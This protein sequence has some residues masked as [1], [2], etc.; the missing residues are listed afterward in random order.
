MEYKFESNGEIIIYD[1]NINKES[2][3]E[4]KE[5]IFD[6][7]LDDKIQY[8]NLINIIDG[9]L[10][11]NIEYLD[12]LLEFELNV[13]F[14]DEEIKELE[15]K[16]SFIVSEMNE[17]KI[18]DKERINLENSLY[19]D[20]EQLKH[21]KRIDKYLKQEFFDYL[22]NVLSCVELKIVNSNKKIRKI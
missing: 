11:D 15:N 16:I 2:L 12:Y 17:V 21:Y 1:I 13:S 5:N 20:K 7:G 8:I 6:N 3:I 4:Q 22:L 14:L 19:F 9:L 18:T 10:N